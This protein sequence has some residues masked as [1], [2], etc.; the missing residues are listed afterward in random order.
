[1]DSTGWQVWFRHRLQKS[2][3]VLR[4]VDLMFGVRIGS[5]KRLVRLL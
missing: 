3:H 4:L 1:M 2:Q 5:S